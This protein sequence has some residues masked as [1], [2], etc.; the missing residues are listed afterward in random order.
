PARLTENPANSWAPSVIATGSVV[1]LAWFDQK[2]APFR[3]LEA[4][5]RLD[6]VMRLLG[7]PVEPPPRGIRVPHPEEAAK[8]RATEKMGQVQAAADAWVQAGGDAAKL[9]A[10]MKT[11]QEMAKPT[12]LAEADAKLDEALRLVGIDPG[13]EEPP[14][15]EPGW[16]QRFQSKMQR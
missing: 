4:E 3:P 10:I 13:N 15:D 9:R 16:Q 5:A 2:G 8:R 12:G 1:H 6:E 11:L 7:L 14:A